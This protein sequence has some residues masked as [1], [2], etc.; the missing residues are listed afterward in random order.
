LSS[1]Q[2]GA[3]ASIGYGYDAAGNITQ[4]T[5][6]NGQQVT[7]GFDADERLASTKDWLENTVTFGYDPNSNQT[8]TTLPDTAGTVDTSP[9]DDA[10]QLSSI[11]SAQGQNTL[12]SMNYT[13]NGDGQIT[14]DSEA[15]LPGSGGSYAYNQLGQLSAYNGSSYTY[16]QADDPTQQN[17]AAGFQ[18]NAGNELTAGPTV[19]SPNPTAYGYDNEGERT[20]TT[21]PADVAVAPTGYGYDQADD[22]VSASR[23]ASGSS[24]AI[25]DSYAYNGDGLRQSETTA[26]GTS[27][28][29]WDVSGSLPLL[30]QDGSTSFIYGP[31]GLP[32]EQIDGSGN[33]LYYHHDQQG[34]TRALTDAYG[35][36][37]GTFS[38][39]PYGNPTG[40]TGT[41]TT[42][43]G[44][45][46][47]L[48]DADTGLIY[49]RARVYDPATGQF[50]T[51][52]PLDA[53][54]RQ[55]Y[56]YAGND[57]ID[58][59]DP[60][61]L[62]CAFGYCL[63]F[64]PVGGLE[65][66]ANFLA[67]MANT[68]VSTATLGGEHVTEPFCG[69]VL[70]TTYSMGGWVA[71]IDAGLASGGVVSGLVKGALGEVAVGAVKLGPL[72][73]PIAGAVTG[74]VVQG[75]VRGA[76]VSS[77]SVGAGV[78]AGIVGELSTGFFRGTSASG[79]AG[80]VSTVVGVVW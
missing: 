30:A 33:V 77:S 62:L 76:S 41:A 22:L 51:R 59:S 4:L 61:G 57:P 46:G 75:K 60:S 32:A 11:T 68:V 3:G 80:L 47:Q 36:V 19:G 9:F 58:M 20:T 54:T 52:D 42:P 79:V 64:H 16:D 7:R 65:A 44:Y 35:N 43:L 78:G 18:F 53:Q 50:L 72:A 1:V 28:L 29:T 15:G 27:Q 26:S 12:A 67:G 71:A 25:T 31:D 73:G 13:R 45:D 14:A 8:T 69:G 21:P 63:G 5:Y 34:S 10:D 48:T 49:L 38:Y 39:D 56:E 24:P 17:G 2:N 55:A 66:G 6:P 37:V 23:A 74:S 70:G 40:S